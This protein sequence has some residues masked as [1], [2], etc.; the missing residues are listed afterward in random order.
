MRRNRFAMVRGLGEV[1]G[2]GYASCCLLA[3]GAGA[4]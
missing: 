3:A 2:V 1:L 4:G